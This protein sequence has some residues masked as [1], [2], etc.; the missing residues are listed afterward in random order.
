MARKKKDIV[1]DDLSND[2]SLDENDPTQ[3]KTLEEA[4]T[5]LTTLQAEKQALENRLRKGELIEVKPLLSKLKTILVGYRM[6]TMN[7]PGTLAKELSDETEPRIIQ[8]RL[9]EELE[10]NLNELAEG[11]ELYGK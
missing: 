5:L 8:R 4:R 2:L 6:R 3:G 9:T 11:L 7:L 10:K 1:R